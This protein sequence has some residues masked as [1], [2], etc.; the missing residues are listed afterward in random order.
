MYATDP[1]TFGL[2]YICLITPF[3]FLTCYLAVEMKAAYLIRRG[4]RH[5]TEEEQLEEFILR[6]IDLIEKGEDLLNRLP[7]EGLLAQHM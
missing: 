4:V 6:V 1:L 2:F 7:L 3:G 5:L